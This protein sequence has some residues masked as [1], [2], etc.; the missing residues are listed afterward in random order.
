MAIRYE[1]SIHT[2]GYD[3]NG[4]ENAV[5]D[6]QR[7]FERPLHLGRNPWALCNDSDDNDEHTKESERT[8]FCKLDMDQRQSRAMSRLE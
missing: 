4:L 2:E 8:G 1:Q 5:V 6:Y 7:P 3:T